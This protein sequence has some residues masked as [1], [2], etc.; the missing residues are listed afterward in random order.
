MANTYF[1]TDG[2]VGT[3]IAVASTTQEFD[4]NTIVN[5]NDGREYLYVKAGEAITNGYLL[6]VDKDG[7]AYHATVALGDKGYTP[8]IA[9]VAIASGSYAFVVRRGQEVSSYCKAATPGVPLY[10][11]TTAGQLTSTS[12]SGL[13]VNGIV[14]QSTAS[15]VAVNC[16]ITYPHFEVA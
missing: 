9:P 6:A 12:T 1:I 13:K 8:A 14:A 10:I 3:K 15:A 5:G 4:L 7:N 11:G 2:A 16:V